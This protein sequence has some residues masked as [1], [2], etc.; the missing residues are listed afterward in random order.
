MRA[1]FTMI[2]LM[3]S[4]VIIAILAAISL[5]I[6]SAVMESAD[7]RK[8]QDVLSLLDAAMTEYEQHMGRPMSYGQG[9]GPGDEVPGDTIVVDRPLD[10]VSE[11]DI[12][13]IDYV[14]GGN[15][16][17]VGF[18]EDWSLTPESYDSWETAASNYIGRQLMGKLLARLKSVASCNRILA[19]IAEDHWEDITPGSPNPDTRYLIDAWGRPIVAVFSGREWYTR[20]TEASGVNDV[21]GD[22]TTN[23][24][25]KDTD[26]TIRTFEERAFGPAKGERIYFMSTGPDGRYGWVNFT[27]PTGTDFTP[28]ADDVRYHR[29]EDNL[30]SYEVRQW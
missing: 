13:V 19:R 30:Y 21:E 29:T 20:G 27:H 2:E 8:T 1:A 9:D 4:I 17:G 24:P 28:D 15:V 11:Y 6:G 12:A 16:G 25:L 22:G 10:G 3:V 14:P 18:R 23:T 5:S 7:R 26:G